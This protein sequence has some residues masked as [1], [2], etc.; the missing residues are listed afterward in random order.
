MKTIWMLLFS[1]FITN[2]LLA[3]EDEPSS[4]PTEPSQLAVGSFWEANIRGN[5]YIINSSRITSIG[6]QEYMAE[7]VKI[8]EV[9]ITSSSSAI[10][11]F[12]Y[13]ELA[14]KSSSLNGVSNSISRL[15]QLTNGVADRAGIDPYIVI[16]NYPTTT[17]AHT[18]E[19]RL[20]NLSSIEQLYKSALKSLK[21]QTNGS[22]TE[23][24]ES[25]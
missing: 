8:S 21:T 15:E 17:H 9:T 16:K 18:I 3:Q 22:F 19:Y 11:R 20:Q 7:G 23:T 14:G 5:H 1:F 13:I 25:E 12:Y 2:L 24:K 10:A 4:I 6:K